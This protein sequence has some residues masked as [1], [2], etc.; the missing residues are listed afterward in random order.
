MTVKD[1]SA[2]HVLSDTRRSSG[3]KLNPMLF[4]FV[5][6]ALWLA[7]AI[8][9]DPTNV[10]Q[11][12]DFQRFHFPS[13]QR[14]A[15]KPFGDAIADY[16]AAPFPLFYVLGGW[17]YGATGSVLVLR[18]WTVGLA[19]GILLLVF[20]LARRLAPQFRAN[21]QLAVALTLA[22]P[23]FRGQ[24]VY[25]NTDIL[26]LLFAL[27]ALYLVSD[28][29]LPFPAPRAASALVL[30]CCAVYTRQFY[31]FMPAYILV[32]I[33]AYTPWKG[34]LGAAALCLALAAP[35]LA[36]VVF[37]HGVTPPGFREH[38]T[39][40]SITRSIPAVV[41]LLSFYA[42]PLAMVTAWRYRE[43]FTTD[44]RSHRLQALIAPFFAIGAYLL[45]TGV[46]GVPEVTGGGMPLHFLRALPFPDHGRAILPAVGVALGGSY[47]AY[48]VHQN[49][50]RNSVILLVALCFLPTGILYQRY[51]DPLMPLLYTSV[52]STR[53]VSPATVSTALGLT[54][55]FE[56]AI[57][58]VAAA[59][60]MTVFGSP[61]S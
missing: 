19:L 26:A 37:W 50:S 32:R 53:E 40:P 14:F 54:V 61:S 48:L 43:A 29:A 31:V 34:R 21:A 12:Q 58:A 23:Y 9:L 1:N 24:S 52:V 51:F 36:L 3:I 2:D 6:A 15:E 49:P 57:A 8:G 30:A 33:Y 28:H 27:A 42:M 5:G 13:I 10:P 35:V 18:A 16:P 44:L 22:S 56:L 38:A 46:A 11:A 25:A 4:L 60:Y 7:S 55:L 59:H 17:L 47:L 20:G 45:L 39:M 41:L